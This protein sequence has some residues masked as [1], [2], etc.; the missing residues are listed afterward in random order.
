VLPDDFTFPDFPAIDAN[1]QALIGPNAT[2]ESSQLDV[3][4][5]EM[6]AVR[7]GVQNLYLWGWAEYD[8][9]FPSTPRRRTE[10]CYRIF[11]MGDPSNPAPNKV[12]FR[13]S[14][15]KTHN[16]ADGECVQ[17][18]KTGSPKNPLSIT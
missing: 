8:D 1:T 16:G 14:L 11:V 12:S 9:V 3:L 5:N 6:R 17:P 10:F 15:H 2:I 13:W 7:D 4:L 18:I